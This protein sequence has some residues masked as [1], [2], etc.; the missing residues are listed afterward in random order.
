MLFQEFFRA[1]NAK[2]ITTVGTG[3]ELSIVK[4]N[5]EMCDGTIEVDSE[6]NKGTT[7]KVLFKR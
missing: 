1:S 7:F 5:V 3:L 4:V 6:V 2:K